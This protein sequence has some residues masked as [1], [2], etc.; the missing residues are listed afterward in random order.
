[1]SVRIIGV[2]PGGNLENVTDY[3]GGTIVTDAIELNVNMATNVV[4]DGTTTRQI[5]REEVILGMELLMQYVMR[6]SWP[7]A[8]S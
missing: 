6:M 4:T 7:P 8:S 5:S 2:P 1:M 3:T